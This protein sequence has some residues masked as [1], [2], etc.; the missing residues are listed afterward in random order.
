MMKIYVVMIEFKDGDRSPLSAFVDAA[1]AL[2]ATKRHE[3]VASD[4]ETTFPIE[5]IM[6]WTS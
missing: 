4:P 3:G 2:K 6:L 5:E 1:E